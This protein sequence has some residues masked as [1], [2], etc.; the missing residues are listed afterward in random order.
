MSNN[1]NNTNKTD[2]RNLPL[3]AQLERGLELIRQAIGQGLVDSMAELW[4]QNSS[5]YIF[6]DPMRDQ[7]DVSY[8][9]ASFSWLAEEEA[10]SC[11]VDGII[12]NFPLLHIN[13]WDYGP[14]EK[15]DFYDL[16]D[17]DEQDVISGSYDGDYDRYLSDNPD[18]DSLSDRC[19]EVM[20]WYA[21]DDILT[22]KAESYIK[23]GI[24]QLRKLETERTN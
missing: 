2:Y 13:H 20:A 4:S 3:S 6:Y 17:D 16:F 12:E 9:A 23:S 15:L 1:T 8:T 24:D 10:K 19:R 11:F 14:D 5:A 22:G 21:K 7:L 18:V